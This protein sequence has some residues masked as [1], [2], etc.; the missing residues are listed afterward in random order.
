M[1]S[2]QVT[3][4]T[5]RQYIVASI[6]NNT[7]F[8][9]R[10][11]HHFDGDINRALRTPEGDRSTQTHT[12]APQTWAPSE[13]SSVVLAAASPALPQY[14]T[15]TPP[16]SPALPNEA[17]AQAQS[18][19]CDRNF[20]SETFRCCVRGGGGVHGRVRRGS[21]MSILSRQGDV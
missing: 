17:V 19:S 1:A 8:T 15:A 14:L 18:P 5:S 21:F 13:S 12:F 20:T 2:L 3:S 11:H 16:G 4:T 7:H 6:D 9:N 10:S